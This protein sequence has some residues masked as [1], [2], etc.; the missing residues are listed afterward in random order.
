MQVAVVVHQSILVVALIPLD[1]ADQ[2]VAA[3]EAYLQQGHLGLLTLAAAVV[4]VVIAALH[5]QEAPAAPVS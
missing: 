5:K 2:V 1:L 3:A 4:V